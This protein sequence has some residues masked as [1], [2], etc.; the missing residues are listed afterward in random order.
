MAG[1]V[2]L[3][4]V[5][6]TYQMGEVTIKAADGIS[7]D[8]EKGEFVIVVG[9][10]GAGKTTVLNILGGMDTATS[11]KVL[12][13]GAEI[14][15]YR[16]KNLIQYR[17]EDIGFVF[18]FYNLMQN[19]TALENVELAMQICKH[20]LDASEVLAEVG[21]EERMN[22]FPAQLSGGEQ[23]RVAIAR[24]IVN[25]PEIL[26]LDEPLGALDYKMR[27][28]MQL[29]LKLMHE[30]LG[31]TFIFV[32]HDQE[33]AL[34]MSDK[35]VVM[36]NGEIQ[37]VGTPEEI[38]DE[39]KN[40][41]VADFIGESNIFNGVMTGHK[42]VSFCQ[43]E[44]D[45]VDDIKEGL[46]VQAVI[47]PEDVVLTEV[48]KGKLQGEVLSS[49]FKGTFHEITVLHNEKDEIVAQASGDIA[50][51]TK[52]GVDILPDSIHLMHFNEKANHFT[53]MI[54]DAM[55]I[56]LVDG[57]IKVDM[58][59]LFPGSTLQDGVLYDKSGHPIETEGRKVV[60]YINPRQAQLSD[61]PQV[62]L[63]QGHIDS[64]IYMGDH[65]S[66]EVRSSNDE[67]YFVYDEYLWNIGDYVSV[68][69]PD[70]G[71]SVTLAE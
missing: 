43:T 10:S 27:K 5:T 68:V 3:Q 69:V 34:T 23:Q 55:R 24:A 63:V 40:A 41:F 70:T 47:R 49:I 50:K 67:L 36:S 21:L 15:K 29:E 19:L 16:G 54:D 4:D 22:N 61:D 42:K 46:R 6:K 17:R 14:S 2:S 59:K 38:Y 28:E 39:P 71:I 7:F 26:L 44:F 31:I 62:G 37:Q 45:C 35:I 20:P 33:E 12:V 9:P 51:G 18:Q 13:D 1:Y 53:G 65:Y 32:T 48:G 64:L 30:Q 8:V 11:G 60:V 57:S 66:Y 56:R 25:E 52:V 58:T